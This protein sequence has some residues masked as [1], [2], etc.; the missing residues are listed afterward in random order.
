[1][2]NPIVNTSAITRKIA[3]PMPKLLTREGQR[4]LGHRPN[5]AELDRCYRHLNKSMANILLRPGW[6]IAERLV[7]SEAAFLN[8]RTFLRQMGLAGAA[9]LVAIPLA[10]CAKA[11]P[12]EADS[13]T[14]RATNTTAPYQ[15]SPLSRTHE[16]DV[17]WTSSN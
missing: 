9:G 12:P 6:H 17:R 16:M 2:R 11:E 7:T 3:L 14:P 13:R 1:F 8:R 4:I 5:F 15:R 10:G